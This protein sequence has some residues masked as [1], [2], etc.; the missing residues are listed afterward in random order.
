MENMIK[1]KR[2]KKVENITLFSYT[3]M[4]NTAEERQG[5]PSDNADNST[6]CLAAHSSSGILI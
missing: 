2:K 3:G 6:S 5:K 4:R 1:K